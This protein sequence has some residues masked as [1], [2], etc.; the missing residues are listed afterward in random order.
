MDRQ[1]KSPRKKSR[2]RR[3]WKTAA[4]IL[5]AAVVAAASIP[6][7]TRGPKEVRHEKT[8]LAARDG[9]PVPPSENDP[10][11][12]RKDSPDASAALPLRVM[13]LNVAHGRG[14]GAHQAM[15]KRATIES[16]LD[17][18]AELLRR[19]RPGIVA[20]QEADGPSAWSGSFNHV[21]YVA[22]RAAFGH[23]ARGEHVKGLKLSYGTA[24][25]SRLP[26]SDA[27]SVTFP[28]SPP[29][30]SKG[31]T[32]ASISW[33][34]KPELQVDLVSVHLDFLS[35]AVRLQ[36]VDKLTETLEK[37]GRPVIVLGDFN[38]QWTDE[39]SS[40]RRLAER[41]ELEVYRSDATDLNSFPTLDK[42]LDW[43][44]IS[45]RFKFTEYR[46]LGDRV[47]DHRAVLAVVAD[48]GKL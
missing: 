48:Q 6:L 30:F 35:S 46:V 28:P 9:A 16:Q 45:P 42:R 4:V 41:R 25:V 19:E 36:Q 13:T 37:R 32:V 33:P 29:T 12:A 47:S 1:S 3:L 14:E 5:V 23:L 17:A 10:N 27:V 18:I 44:L 15:Q 24:I 21:E 39:E 8:E 43:I 26:L 31:F 40:V 7:A 38:C 22:K 34:G 20:M 2:R 11:A